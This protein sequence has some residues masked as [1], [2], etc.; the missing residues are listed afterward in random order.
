V[1]DVESVCRI[2]GIEKPNLLIAGHIKPW[3]TCD[4]AAERLD[5]FNGLMLA[6]H[7]DF[8]FDR[9]LISFEDDGRLLLSSQLQ[10]ADAAKLGLHTVQRP[11]P[12]PFR[13]ESRAY[14]LH[15][16]STVYIP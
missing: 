12:R 15:H 2:T 1:L 16:R 5:G 4:S 13:D 7:A 8:L 11:A 14:F 9:G 3:R 10:E 6:P